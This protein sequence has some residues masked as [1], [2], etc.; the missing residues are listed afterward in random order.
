M[1]GIK[2]FHHLFDEILTPPGVDGAIRWREELFDGLC[3][4]EYKDI[5]TPKRMAFA[6]KVYEGRGDVRD[7]LPVHSN[8]SKLIQYINGPR[9]KIFIGQDK[10]EISLQVC[11]LVV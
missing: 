8:V 7:T 4:D 11:K 3:P 1:Q 5:V 2:W 6:L 9:G 10:S